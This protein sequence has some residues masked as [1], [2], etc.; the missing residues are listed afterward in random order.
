MDA[1]HLSISQA[2]KILGLRRSTAY[3]M[4]KRGEI[5]TVPVTGPKGRKFGVPVQWVEAY[6]RQAAA[7]GLRQPNPNVLWELLEY[8]TGLQKTYVRT[9]LFLWTN[10]CWVGVQPD[11]Q[12][13]VKGPADKQWLASSYQEFLNR[14]SI[15]P[16]MVRTLNV[17]EKGLP[18]QHRG[19]VSLV[20]GGEV[21]W[22]LEAQRLPEASGRP[23]RIF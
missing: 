16:E 21:T 20:F 10:G 15:R 12:I 8:L 19:R 22:E 18:K 13:V 6:A 1:G 17:L 9:V 7:R 5:P 14:P 23:S 4:A 2:A 3:L 11:G